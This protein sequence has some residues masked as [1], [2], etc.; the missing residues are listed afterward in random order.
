MTAL[1]ASFLMWAFC[2]SDV[3]PDVPEPEGRLSNPLIN[4]PIVG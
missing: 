2:S 1:I 3:P 4:E